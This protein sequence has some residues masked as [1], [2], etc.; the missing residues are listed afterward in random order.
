MS[1]SFTNSITVQSRAR[2]LVPLCVGAGAYLFFLFSATR[3]FRNSDSFW[4]IKIGQWILDHRALPYTDF[5]PSRARRTMDLDVLAVAGVF[6]FPTR[7][8]TG[9]DR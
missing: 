7:N 2:A 6:A 8:G 1:L 9:P 4:Q 5:I 3:C